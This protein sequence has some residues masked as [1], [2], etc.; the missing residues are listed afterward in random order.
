M[1]EVAGKD[2]AVT[3][4]VQLPG[5]ALINAIT[6]MAA[7]G[8][9]S[10]FPKARQLVG[11]A[12]LGGIVHQSSDNLWQ[13]P[14]SCDGRAICAAQC[15]TSPRTPSSVI[16]TGNGCI[17]HLNHKG[18]GKALIAIARQMLIL[19]WHLLTQVEAD[20]NANPVQVANSYLQLS[21][22][23]S[24]ART[25]RASHPPASLC[26]RRWTIWASASR[27]SNS[28]ATKRPANA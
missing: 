4:L 15:S 18:N 11:Y 27:S 7:I 16:P 22:T 14:T 2:S 6:I 26:A 9:I 8:D 21:T 20:K 12:G 13:G 1:A 3:L 24:A 28:H 23:R 10:R 17:R 19:V 25:S 5:I